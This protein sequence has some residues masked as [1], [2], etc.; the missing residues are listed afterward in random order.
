MKILIKTVML[1]VSSSVG[2]QKTEKVIGKCST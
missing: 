1:E 2:T